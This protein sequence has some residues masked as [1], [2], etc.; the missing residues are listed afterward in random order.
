MSSPKKCQ[1]QS[2]PRGPTGPR[3]RYINLYEGYTIGDASSGA[4]FTGSDMTNLYL[5][6]WGSAATKTYTANTSTEVAKGSSATVDWNAHKKLSL[7][8]GFS[9]INPYCTYKIR[10]A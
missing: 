5:T 4:T 8:Y 2:P 10:W 6:I 1:Q 3:T 7:P 9:Y